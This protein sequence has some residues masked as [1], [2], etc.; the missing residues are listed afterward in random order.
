MIYALLYNTL[1]LVLLL[2]NLRRLLKALGLTELLLVVEFLQIQESEKHCK[3]ESKNSGGKHTSQ[4]LN[5][6]QI[7]LL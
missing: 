4:N 6:L 3:K 7:M 1:L 5:T 2:I